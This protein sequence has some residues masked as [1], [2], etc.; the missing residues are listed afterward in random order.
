MR[1]PKF[2]NINER[3]AAL[4]AEI[5]SQ[6]PSPLQIPYIQEALVKR[7]KISLSRTLLRRYLREKMSMTYRR[8]GVVGKHYDERINLLKR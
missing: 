4:I 6:C 1:R 7:Q 5:I 8:L 2:G 3:T